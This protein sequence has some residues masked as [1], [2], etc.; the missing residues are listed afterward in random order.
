MLLVDFCPR[1]GPL[2]QPNPVPAE[3]GQHRAHERG[4][5]LLSRGV[6]LIGSVQVNQR[7]PWMLQAVA[8]GMSLLEVI[9]ASLEYV[10]MGADVLIMIYMHGFMSVAKDEGTVNLHLNRLRPFIQLCTYCFMQG[11]WAAGH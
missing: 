4:K 5:L 2:Q 3:H 11:G 7:W 6:G 8:P 10:R 9:D 1:P